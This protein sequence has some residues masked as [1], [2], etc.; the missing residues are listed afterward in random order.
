M[1]K[2]IHTHIDYYQV[3]DSGRVRRIKAGKNTKIG[4]ILKPGLDRHGY[5][6][7]IL[8]RQGMGTQI[9]IHQLVIQAFVGHCPDG[10]EVRHIDGNPLN[11]KLSNLQ[12]GTHSQN[13]LDRNKH[14]TGNR[15]SKHGLS[16]LTENDVDKIKL[17]ATQGISHNKIANLF[18]VHQSTIT[19]IINGKRWIWHNRKERS[20]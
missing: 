20:D 9:P 7:V 8:F 10:Y 5:P 3:S 11:N 15:G 14:G 17:L 18:S 6:F 19:R 16:K 4:K 2:D 12:Y 13:M 1:W